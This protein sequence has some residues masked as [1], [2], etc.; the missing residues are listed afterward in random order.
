MGLYDERILPRLVDLNCGTKGMA[1]FRRRAMEGMAGTVIEIGFGSGLNLPE[2]P[3]EVTRVHAVEPNALARER[4]MERI[5]AA[6]VPVEFVGLDGESIPLPDD[7]CDAALATF[8]LCTIPHAD[9]ALAE[10]RRVLRPGGTLHFLEHGRSPEPRVQRW[11]DRIEPLQ[12]RFA[13]GCH[14]TREPEVML[15]DAGFEISELTQRDVTGP[16]PWTY[17]SWGR[18]RNP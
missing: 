18:A 17:F 10:L 16:K 2:Y 15:T 3:A 7:S 5:R 9:R 13:G 6:P 11:Q 1:R 4:A 12:K 8:V 14:L